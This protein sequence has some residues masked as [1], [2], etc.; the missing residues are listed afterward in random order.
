MAAPGPIPRRSDAEAVTTVTIALVRHWRVGP[1]PAVLRRALFGWA[2]N[3]A[4]VTLPRSP[5]TARRIG[6]IAAA[7]L[8]LAALEEAATVTLA[9][10]ACARTFGG[11]PGAATTQRRKRAVTRSSCGTW[12]PTLSTGSGGRL[13]CRPTIDH[14]VVAYPALVTPAGRSPRARRPRRHQALSSSSSPL[15][16]MD[17]VGR[18]MEA[19]GKEEH[20]DG[21][22]AGACLGTPGSRHLHAPP[23]RT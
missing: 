5:E 8:P 12:N 15:R 19:E 16:A 18:Q 21:V 7:S 9:L 4:A 3:L 23:K 10:D 6:L 14:R 11:K 20:P 2:L 13:R 22:G 17:A 1:D